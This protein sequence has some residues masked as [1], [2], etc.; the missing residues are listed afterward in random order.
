MLNI[1][2]WEHRDDDLFPIPYSRV[3]LM[4]SE[5]EKFFKF[6]EYPV[7]YEVGMFEEEHYLFSN[8]EYNYIYKKD[9]DVLTDIKYHFKLEEIEDDVNESDFFYKSFKLT[10][11]IE[12]TTRDKKYT[13]ILLGTI[14]EFSVYF[15]S[16]YWF[17]KELNYDRSL[18]LVPLDKIEYFDKVI[19]Y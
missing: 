13:M 6:K 14:S 1:Q 19:D 3:G 9:G 11:E 8:G 10:I 16:S 5:F 4:R 7:R 12:E 17:K 2:A 15:D 18:L